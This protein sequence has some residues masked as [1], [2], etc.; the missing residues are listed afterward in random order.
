MASGQVFF[1]PEK[2]QYY[3]VTGISA[4]AF[5]SGP[6]GLINK[7]VTWMNNG[8]NQA[9]QT[10]P[11][12]F[13]RQPFTPNATTQQQLSGMGNMQTPQWMMDA[14]AQ[15]IGQMGGNANL[16]PFGVTQSGFP[17]MASLSPVQPSAPQQPAQPR[18]VTPA[19]KTAPYLQ[20]I[21]GLQGAVGGAFDASH[22][23]LGGDK[24]SGTS[25]YTTSMGIK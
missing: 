18:T 16:P 3:T 17:G 14:Y 11:Q 12:Q 19:G 9:Q 6:D 4:P 8:P 5:A 13:N 2:Q 1:D 10:Q 24:A 25:T 15:K 22:A 7:K 23:L 20:T 21:Q